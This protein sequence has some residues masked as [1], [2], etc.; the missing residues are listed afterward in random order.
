MI[1][2]RPELS[3]C[4]SSYN[5]REWIYELVTDILSC[6]D[7]RFEVIVTD[8]C[9]ADGTYEILKSIN[10][11]RF[12][13]YQNACNLGPTANYMNAVWSGTGKKI[14]FMIDKDKLHVHKLSEF[15]DLLE[16]NN[17]SVGICKYN[18]KGTTSVLKL[19]KAED[20]TLKL[21]YLMIHPSGYLYNRDY[22]ELSRGK[23]WYSNVD[24]VGFFPF[25]F[26]N[27]DLAYLGNGIEIAFRLIYPRKISKNDTI[28]KSHTYSKKNNNLFFEPNKR[29]EML[30]KCFSHIN[31][32][33]VGNELKKK[34]SIKLFYMFWEYIT[35]DY[36][37][38][39][40]DPIRCKHY[41]IKPRYV[42]YSEF[43][44]NTWKCCIAFYKYT[45][46]EPLT[47]IR[48]IVYVCY[49]LVCAI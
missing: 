38:I 36:R 21:S 19:P 16:R 42:N 3:I 2:C 8:N 15:I 13:L 23:E 32:I 28:Q 35:I 1:E 33:N 26:L 45:D 49:N 34:I 4:I 47:K 41:G 18:Y 40:M 24:N 31:K 7:D 5:N 48:A 12:K 22:L 37:K 27:A 14:L 46:I 11:C 29:I 10:D 20:I 43:I 9:S 17:F 44:I 39:L 30:V 25:E 6:N